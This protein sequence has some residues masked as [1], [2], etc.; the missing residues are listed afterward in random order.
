M[1]ASLTARKKYATR[2]VDVYGIEPHLDWHRT[3]PEFAKSLVQDFGNLKKQHRF[4][5][6]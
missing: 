6:L 3:N 5:F 2:G 4:V 1:E